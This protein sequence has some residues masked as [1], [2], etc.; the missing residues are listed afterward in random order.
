M[1]V[2]LLPALFLAALPAM[3]GDYDAIVAAIKKAWPDK[4]HVAVV[5]DQANSKGSV[6]ALAGA[7]GGMKIMLIDVKGP[8][9]MGK[10]LGTLSGQKPD[11]VVLIAG[12]RVAGDGSPAATFLIQR[13]AGVKVPVTATTEAG[14]KQGAVAAAGPGTGGRLLVNPKAAAAVG[15]AVPEGGTPI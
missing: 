3:T 7:A 5:C 10:A 15:V 14:V 11:V 13:M 2:R 9:D 12:D 8:Q 6:A 4:T 1:R